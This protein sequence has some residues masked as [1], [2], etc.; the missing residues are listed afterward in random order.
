[1]KKKGKEKFIKEEKRKR[2]N[3]SRELG[4]ERPRQ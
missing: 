2:K 4:V 1:M 3:K